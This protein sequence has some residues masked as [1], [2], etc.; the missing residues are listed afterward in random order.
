M[1]STRLPLLSAPASA[2]TG[3]VSRVFA[4]CSFWAALAFNPRYIWKLPRRCSGL[5][6]SVST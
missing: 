5:V 6:S 4:R 1:S 2:R 3:I